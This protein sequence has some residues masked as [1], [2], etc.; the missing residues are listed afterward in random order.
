MNLVFL[1][2]SISSSHG[3][4]H[5]TNYRALV[6]ELGARGHHVLF[7]ERDAP[8]HESSRDLRELRG[9][10]LSMYRSLD[11][12]AELAGRDIA[13]AD[14]VIVGSHVPE[15]AAV[16]EYVL[17]TAEGHTVFYDMDTP[18]TLAK[19]DAGDHEYLTPALIP[20]FQLYLSSTGGP[21]LRR[22]ETQY[23]ARRAIAFHCLVDP[24][25]YVSV[26]SRPCWDL[27][28][29]GTYSPD[30]Q[31]GLEALMLAPARALR[32]RRFVVAGPQYPESVVWPANVARIQNVAHARHPVFFGA[33]RFTL[34]LTRAPMREAGWSPGLRL[35]EAAVCGTAIISDHWQ[36]LEEFLTP[37]KEILV[38]RSADDVLRALIETGIEARLAMAARARQRVLR[39]HTATQRIDQLEAELRE[40]SPLGRGPSSGVHAWEVGA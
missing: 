16:A 7:C 8:L 37:E 28:Y 24:R 31:S 12:L 33:Q 4:S 38:A 27:G 11:E 36:G 21:T 39:E 18:V 5:A 10:R 19:L 32:A 26:A 40:L 6:R 34:N 9:A 15:G 25:G 22:L 30:R 20:R 23:G 13:T 35:F 29:L 14:V 1:G 3:S 17:T 2:L